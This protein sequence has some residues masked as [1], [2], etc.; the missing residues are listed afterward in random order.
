MKT[1]KVAECNHDLLEGL[2][3]QKVDQLAQLARVES[4]GQFDIRFY[5]LGHCF[6]MLFGFA[7]RR[8]FMLVHFVIA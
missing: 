7:D 1:R 4:A 3:K 8:H 2:L 5:Q 6:A